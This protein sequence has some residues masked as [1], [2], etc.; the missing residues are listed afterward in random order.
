MSTVTSVSGRPLE[1]SA[2]LQNRVRRD[3]VRE[4]R[5]VA[6]KIIQIGS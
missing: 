1:L 6:D 4:P 5:H 2:V 3:E